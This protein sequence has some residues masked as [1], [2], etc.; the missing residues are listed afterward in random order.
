LKQVRKKINIQKDWGEFFFT[1]LVIEKKLARN[2][3]FLAE[4]HQCFGFTGF[5]FRSNCFAFFRRQ[6]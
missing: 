5:L 6:N 4:K 2:T 1:R 3:R